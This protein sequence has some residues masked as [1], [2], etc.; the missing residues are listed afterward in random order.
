MASSRRQA[1]ERSSLNKALA[2]Y[3]LA[4]CRLP[5]CDE[6]EFAEVSFDVD[7]GTFLQRNL[8]T[9]ERVV[10]QVFSGLETQCLEEKQQYESA[11]QEASEQK[12]NRW[13]SY[14]GPARVWSL[15]RSAIEFIKQYPEAKT[16]VITPEQLRF[17]VRLQHFVTEDTSDFYRPE[18][19]RQHC[20]VFEGVLT[21]Q[22]V[23]SQLVKDS[24]RSEWAIGGRGTFVVREKDTS[25][26]L[27]DRK[28]VIAQFQHD[29]V[30]NLESF[31]LEYCRSKGVS[32]EAEKRFMQAVTTQ[33]SQAGLANLD[34]SSMAGTYFVSGQGLEQRVNYNLSTMDGEPHMGETVQLTLLC[35]KTGFKHYHKE[36]AMKKAQQAALNGEEVDFGPSKC[37]PSSYLYQYATLR[38]TFGPTVDGIERTLCS[39]I[40][41]LDEVHIIDP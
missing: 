4:Q 32:K 34:R 7:S 21:E 11:Q 6:G 24:H 20:D 39:V 10:H 40:D 33:M 36:D 27:D 22:G 37:S 8:A 14:I 19:A 13:S 38:F 1:D 31:L 35:L 12:R 9:A 18:N 29:F 26:N 17:L 15:T 25:E 3:A 2:G 5:A 41:A 30:T 23:N 28:K 16:R